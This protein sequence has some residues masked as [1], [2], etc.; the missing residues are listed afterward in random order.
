[1]SSIEGSPPGASAGVVETRITQVLE[2]RIDDAILGK[3]G[4]DDLGDAGVLG[5]RA[6]E[7]A[8]IG[9]LA[10]L[11]GIAGGYVFAGHCAPLDAVEPDYAAT[12]ERLVGTPYLWGGRTSLGLDCSGLVQ[13]ALTALG[14]GG[15]RLP[16]SRSLAIASQ[17]AWPE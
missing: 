8:L 3:A 7:A 6:A 14:R 13:T 17:S 9:L 12:A 5:R 16:A 1:M 10:S 15:I 2:D 4:T 11:L